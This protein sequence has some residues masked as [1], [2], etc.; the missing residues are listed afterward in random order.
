VLLPVDGYLDGFI[1][2]LDSDGNFRWVKSI[3][4]SGDQE[5]WA[6]AA[7]PG[8]QG[9]LYIAGYYYGHT[10]VDDV[11]IPE[12]MPITE[13]YDPFISKLDFTGHFLFLAGLGGTGFDFSQAIAVNPAAPGIYSTGFF[14][15]TCDFDP[16]INEYPL[17]SAGNTDLYVIKLD[18]LLTDIDNV[19][20][21][22]KDLDF[23]VYPIPARDELL[24]RIP[25]AEKVQL[26]ITNILGVSIKSFDTAIENAI[27]RL[28]V[29]LIPN[30]VYFLQMNIN[31][32]M[33]S[34]KFIIEH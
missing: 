33:L 19:E 34:K 22:E 32:K 18:D 6:I 20:V 2:A 25:L 1:L 31:N 30:G 23:Q 9:G 26:T 28:D 13:S 12:L 14:S 8:T 10:K 3:T 29:S 16:G 15:G 5:V 24:V 17:V 4:G 11:T 7:S 27:V 21:N